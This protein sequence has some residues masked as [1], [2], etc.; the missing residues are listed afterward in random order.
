MHNV[1]LKRK[2]LLLVPLFFLAFLISA[3]LKAQTP[4]P[5]LTLFPVS[6]DLLVGQSETKEGEINLKNNTGQN[7]TIQTTVRN[8]TATGEEGQVDITDEETPFSLSEWM[9]ITP[10]KQQVK[11]GE[12]VKFEYKITPPENAEAGGHFGSV[13]FAT[14]PDANLEGSGA[15]LSQEVAAIFLVRVPGAVVEKASIETFKTDKKFYEFGPVDFS[16]RVKNEG[17][18]HVRP[19]GVITIQNMWGG[20]DVFGFEGRN[21][22]PNSIRQMP[23]IWT[24]TWLIGKYDANLA[25]T[26]G[27]K[28]EQLYATTSFW[29]FPWR[30]GLVVLAVL[31]VLFLF[32]KRLYRALKIILKGS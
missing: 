7:V 17:G 31:I 25:L 19:A 29:A 9:T 10:E 11:Q 14:V 22:L 5:G 16:I 15:L 30:V 21:V 32:R 24:S 27:S 2:L 1:S 26:F 20:K 28:N 8:F 3:V 12:T 6:F 18:V 13:V 4:N 23:A